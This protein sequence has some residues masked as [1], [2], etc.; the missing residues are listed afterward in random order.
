MNA[1]R[2]K[3]TCQVNTLA[4]LIYDNL[5]F[6]DHKKAAEKYRNALNEYI[7]T[8]ERNK[9]NIPPMVLNNHKK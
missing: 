5:A 4:P 3:L 8:A 6:L 9:E 7:P 1:E 2:F